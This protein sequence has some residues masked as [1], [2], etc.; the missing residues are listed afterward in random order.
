MDLILGIGNRGVAQIR[1]P[2]LLQVV[3]VQFEYNPFL[4]VH[5]SF[6]RG[7]GARHLKLRKRSPAG[8]CPRLEPPRGRVNLAAL[9]RV[10]STTLDARSEE[11]T[12]ELQSL[13]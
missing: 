11:Q 2:L 1:Q 10:T 9:G 7:G 6:A 8:I 5:G 3:Q 4:R 12:S 13:R